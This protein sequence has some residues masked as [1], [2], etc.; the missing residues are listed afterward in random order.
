ML[1]AAQCLCSSDVASCCAHPHRRTARRMLLHGDATLPLGS[2][3]SAVAAL[4]TCVWARQV[5]QHAATGSAAGAHGCAVALR[6]SLSS[7]RLLSVVLHCCDSQSAL[8]LHSAPALLHPRTEG[9]QQ[10][11]P[12]TTQHGRAR[13][14][15]LP[16]HAQQTRHPYSS[17]L[18]LWAI[19]KHAP[20][21]LDF[22]E[23]LMHSLVK[24]FGANREAVHASRGAN[25]SVALVKDHHLTHAERT[26]DCAVCSHEPDRRIRST[27]ICAKCRVHLCIEHC[28]K[29]YHAAL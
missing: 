9:V 29:R 11:T 16:M 22:R 27:Y 3:R 14:I 4:Q 12:L 17:A 28:F 23:E 7:L 18:Q 26:G 5:S 8:R 15:V 10:T 20:R 1:V 19:G 2:V 21:Q 25:T 13:L 24:L 6:A